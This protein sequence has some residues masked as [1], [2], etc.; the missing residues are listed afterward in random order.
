MV[1][2]RVSQ[3]LVKNIDNLNQPDVT[4]ADDHT[5]LE[6]HREV[7]ICLYCCVIVEY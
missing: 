6:C 5:V 7:K 3:S 4:T 1:E 2:K